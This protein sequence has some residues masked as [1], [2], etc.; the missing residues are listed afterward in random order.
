MKELIANYPNYKS[1]IPF[2]DIVR[3]LERFTQINC[4]NPTIYD[5]FLAD[6]STNFATMTYEDRVRSMLAFS[7][8]KIKQTDFFHNNILKISDEPYA[9][10]TYLV[11]ILQALYRVG[12]DY[13]E[14]K[15]P[16]LNIINKF[17]NEK[18][19]L[20]NLCFAK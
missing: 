17:T 8:I 14:S 16:L 5:H 1:R 10:T 12:Y 11:S 2:S 4:R 6:I 20:M 3:L 13:E 7:R 19:N 9:Y 18:N 15:E